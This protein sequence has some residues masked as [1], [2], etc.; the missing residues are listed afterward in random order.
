MKNPTLTSATVALAA[1]AIVIPVQSAQ[2]KVNFGS[3]L[4]PTI[5]PSNSLP[6]LACD[7]MDPS[8]TCS[9]VM[10]EAYGRPDG[11]EMAPVAGTLKRVRV[12]SGGAGS[13][14][15]QLVKAREVGGVWQAKVKAEGPQITVTGQSQANWDTDNYKVESFKVNM[16]IKKGWR[17]SMKSTTTSAVR[18]SSGGDNTLLFQPPLTPG[19]GFRPATGDDGCWTLIEGVIK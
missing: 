15:L 12:I 4:N 6:G 13:F 14:Q 3:E 18:C 19:S 8:T 16:P 2:A 17:L 10:N 7:Q 5:Q 1:A 9:F 11:G